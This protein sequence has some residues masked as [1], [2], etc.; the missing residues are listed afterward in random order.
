MSEPNEISCPIHGGKTLKRKT[1]DRGSWLSHK[2][3]DN[4]CTAGFDMPA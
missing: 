1:N 3:G 4:W 2:D